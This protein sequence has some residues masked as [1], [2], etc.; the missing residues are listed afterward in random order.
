MKFERLLKIYWIRGLFFNGTLLKP[1][2]SLNDMF[3]NLNGLSYKI[4]FNFISRFELNYQLKFKNKKYYDFTI[5]K[6]N[7][8]KLINMYI[9]QIT[10]LGF[11][12]FNLIK[13]NTIRLYLIKSM[14]GRAQ[15]LGKPS[16]GQ[17]TW[18]NSWTS[19]YYNKLLKNF[20]SEIIK[21]NRIVKEV[22]Q[23]NKKLIKHKRHKKKIKIIMEVNYQKKNLWF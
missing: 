18:S 1:I 3:K 13:Y 2:W 15:M 21:N 14:R 9:S 8:K 12:M 23:L 19:F 17:R 20:V 11:K 6:K 16:R 4:K 5:L 10:S 7:K 22:Q